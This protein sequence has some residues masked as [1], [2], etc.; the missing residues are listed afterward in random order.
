MKWVLAELKLYICNWGIN[1]FP[2]RRIRHLYYRKIMKYKIDKSSTIFLKA[3]F[4][5]PGNLIIGKDSVINPSCHIDPR[6]KIIIGKNVSI[7]HGV[8]LVTGDHDPSNAFFLARFRNIIIEDHVFIG[9]GSIILGGITLGKGCIVAAGSV[10]TKDVEAFTI[11]GGVPAKKIGIRNPELK[12][13][14]GYSRL[15]G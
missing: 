15:F 14:G 1:N 12:R 6:G 5:S 11:V 10:V 8:S 7:S 4:T 3:W 2:S 13:E 9:F